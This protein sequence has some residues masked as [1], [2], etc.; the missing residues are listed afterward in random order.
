MKTQILPNQKAS[1]CVRYLR[2]VASKKVKDE[3]TDAQNEGREK[4]SVGSFQLFLMLAQLFGYFAC[5]G[6]AC[7]QQY[8]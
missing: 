4:D 8:Q 2:T 5:L 7:V 1:G 3:E 6:K